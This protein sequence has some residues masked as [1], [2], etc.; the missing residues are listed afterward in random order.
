MF[1]RG[2]IQVGRGGAAGS[3]KHDES[4]TVWPVAESSSAR[5]RRFFVTWRTLGVLGVLPAGFASPIVWMAL[6][7]PTHCGFETSCSADGIL[8]NGLVRLGCVWGAIIFGVGLLV[9]GWTLLHGIDA[10]HGP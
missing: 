2:E 7:E 6:D 5:L 8:S 1:E 9:A 3:A 4:S 10:S